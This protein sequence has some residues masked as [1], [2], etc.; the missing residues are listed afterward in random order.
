M[1]TITDAWIDQHRSDRGG[2]TKDQCAAIGV[3][4]P[5]VAGWKRNAVGRRITDEARSQSERALRAPQ[6]R[7][8][9][10]IDMFIVARVAP[11][12]RN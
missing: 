10:T 1:F 8:A 3:P 5:L 6:A 9:A 7:R 4:W 12:T 2:W 11:Q